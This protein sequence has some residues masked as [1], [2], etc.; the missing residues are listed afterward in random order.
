MSMMVVMTVVDVGLH[1]DLRLRK[2]APFVKSCDV[3][4]Y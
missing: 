3:N 1:L 2:L 4:F